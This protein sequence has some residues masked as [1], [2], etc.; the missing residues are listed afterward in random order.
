MTLKLTFLGTGTS[1]GIPLIGCH[2]DVCSSDNP[3]NNRTRPSVMLSYAP[4]NAGESK[5]YAPIHDSLAGAK[6]GENLGDIEAQRKL[7]KQFVIDTG[8]D[9]REQMI[10]HRVDFVDGI[11]Y[12]HTHADHIYGLDDL[13]RYNAVLQEP[14]SIY[15]EQSALDS[16]RKTFH[17]IF[18]PSV[19]V[20]K[21]FI[22]TLIPTPVVPG[23]S[24]DMYGA[25]WTP[26]RLLHGRL[27][28]LGYRIDLPRID[29]TVASVAYC[30]DVSSIP[31]ETYP[32][33]EDLDVLVIDGL[34][35]RHHPTHMTVDQALEQIDYIKP[36]Q[37]YLTHIAHEIEHDD[38]NSR[39]PEGVSLPFD[40]ME[41][42]I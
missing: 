32:L 12:T 40:G 18:D 14:I 34:R 15:S 4:L 11:F 5:E 17:Y 41:I 36:K 2:C 13:R 24:I 7:L 38:L 33:L 3:K 8:P 23:H 9:F 10:R 16:L 20:N 19:N 35:Y 21:S 26:L 30:T 29:G 37:A 39:L 28:I 1:A 27:P 31:P 22:A 6:I 42:E 25:S